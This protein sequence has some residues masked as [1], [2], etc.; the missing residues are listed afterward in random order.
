M[1][2]TDPE[3][4]NILNE[5]PSESGLCGSCHSV[6]RGVDPYLW[7]Q[8]SAD[9]YVLN[10]LCLNCHSKDGSAKKKTIDKNSHPVNINPEESRIATTLPLFDVKGK[11]VPEGNIEC[12]T[13]HDP[14]RWDPVN[15]FNEPHYDIEGSSKNSFL[16]LENS[17]EPKLCGNCHREEAQIQNTDHDMNVSSVH[18]KNNKGQT[19]VES[20]TCGVCHLAHNSENSIRQWALDLESGNSVMEN[21]CNS[22]HSQGKLENVKVPAIASHPEDII[23]VNVGHS[24]KEETGYFPLFDGTTGELK[25]SGKI[26]CPSCHN[27]HQWSM[28]PQGTKG[29]A[30]MEGDATSSFLR[31]RVEDLLCNKCHGLDSLFR[32][33]YYHTPEKRSKIN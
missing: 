26:S 21:M 13:C 33:L 23:V 22:C 8:N 24:T 20:G 17:P 19:P 32:Y 29:G 4:K 16:R 6:H 10:D 5:T 14:H 1:I 18:L 25:V 2:K 31:N 3:G 9:E 11:R 28:Y 30:D 15:I 7:T 27:A 12:V